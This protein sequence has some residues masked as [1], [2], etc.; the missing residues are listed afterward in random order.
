MRAKSEQYV[1][2]A[3]GEGLDREV[4]RELDTP[5]LNVARLNSS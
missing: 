1:Q 5:H 3:D 2:R 4:C